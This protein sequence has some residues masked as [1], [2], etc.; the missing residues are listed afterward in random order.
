[1][2][3]RRI[4]FGVLLPTRKVVFSGKGD[5]VKLHAL[6]QAQI[7]DM[8]DMAERAGFDIVSVGDSILA[9]PRMEAITTLAAV[10]GRTRRVQLM[11]TILI[12]VLRSPIVLADQVA[13]LDHLASGRLMLG[14]GVGEPTD[15]VR[16]E[17]RDLDVVF[18][19]RGKRSDELLRLLKRLWTEDH[20]THRG[21]FYQ[22]E[23][24]TVDPKPLQQPHPPLI[25]GA[26][27]YTFARKE[28][29]GP[30]RRVA[31]IGDGWIATL[32]MPEERRQ[33][34]NRIR[35]EAES[36]G[37][38]PALI[39]RVCFLSINARP[40]RQQAVEEMRAFLGQYLKESFDEHFGK[41]A[42]IERW[43]AFGTPEDC[44]EL[45]QAHIEAGADTV[46]FRLPRED[47]IGQ[48]MEVAQSIL[49]YFQ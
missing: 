33:A 3:K 7:L 19:K 46:V 36:L 37:R 24:V 20:V 2:Q 40:S 12:P 22:Y 23:D 21:E 14:I 34:W 6:T 31:E 16:K 9:K 45:I 47:Q 41:A 25:I 30:F 48:L 42:E 49:P 43:G 15:I 27:H 13:T 29:E 44:R 39:H 38:D 26:G 17:F 5:P 35:E 1:M 18:N 4:R 11:T 10:A 32:I 8:A 28:V